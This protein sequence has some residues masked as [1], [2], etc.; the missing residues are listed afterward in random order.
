MMLSQH[1]CLKEI[2]MS[3][4]FYPTINIDC[5]VGIAHNRAKLNKYL[6]VQLGHCMSPILI[7]I[8]FDGAHVI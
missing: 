6:C 1:N 8:L 7:F 3:P 2:M 5:G 4:R